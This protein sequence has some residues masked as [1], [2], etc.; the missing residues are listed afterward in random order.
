MSKLGGAG[1]KSKSRKSLDK[2]RLL[3]LDQFHGKSYNAKDVVV[4]K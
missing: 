2:S 1:K 3:F 4:E